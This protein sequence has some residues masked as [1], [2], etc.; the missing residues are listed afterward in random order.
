VTDAD[1]AT[2]SAYLILEVSNPPTRSP[3]SLVE[4]GVVGVVAVI[5]ILAA[6]LLLRRRRQGGRP[7]D[8]TP[9]TPG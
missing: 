2:A 7:P 3:I 8:P 5:A 6:I 4:I 9:T 1:G